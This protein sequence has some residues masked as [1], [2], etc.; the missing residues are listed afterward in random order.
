M[1]PSLTR[2]LAAAAVL[3]AT[4]SSAALGA[5]DFGRMTLCTTF[6]GPAWKVP[7]GD[8]TVGRGKVYEVYVDKAPCAFAKTWATKFVRTPTHG[9]YLLKGPAGWRC[10][11]NFG[12]SQIWDWNGFCFKGTA[13]RFSWGPKTR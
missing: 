4:A 12:V 11:A 5:R 1:N 7:R 13:Q 2:L 6:T 10:Q 3:A 9:N 8:G